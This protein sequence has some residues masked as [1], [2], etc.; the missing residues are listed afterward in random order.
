MSEL[1]TAFSQLLGELENFQ[2]KL[3]SMT[4]QSDHDYAENYKNIIDLV[5]VGIDCY[6]QNDPAN[7]RWVNLV[8]NHRK[9]GGDNQHARYFFV[10]LSERYQYQITGKLSGASYM[11]FTLYGCTQEDSFQILDNRSS[12]DIDINP[13]ASFELNL[14]SGQSGQNSMDLP[15]TVNCLIVR[16]YFDTAAPQKEIPLDIEVTGGVIEHTP[17]SSME[18]TRRL[19]SASNFLKGW[20]NLTPMPWPK[21]KQAYNSIC[22]PFQASDSSGHWSTPDNIH[23]MGFY[24][25]RDDEALV[26][27]GSSVTCRY[28]SCH[29]WNAS[30]QTYD[31]NNFQ[32]ALSGNQLSPDENG[33][34]QIVIANHP[35]QDKF[36]LD[37][38]G[39]HRG[40][41][42][43]R[44]L[45]CSSPPTSIFAEVRPLSELLD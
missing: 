15:E 8:S 36:W 40:F 16:Q 42:Y 11:G 9:I 45:L 3:E 30:M 27:S 10:P 35:A 4:D 38:A 43:F 13:D 32:C 22:N 17:L 23:A 14:G 18:L 37:T 2:N 41:V 28:W 20:A 31:F 44:W 12:E 34:W 24:R 25:L 26:L 7:P 21:E 5:H 33:H 6:V 1:N 39:H 29:L 19:S